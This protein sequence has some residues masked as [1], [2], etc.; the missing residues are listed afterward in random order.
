MRREFYWR[1]RDNPLH[2]DLFEQSSQSLS[3]LASSSTLNMALN[4]EGNVRRHLSDNARPVRKRPVTRIH[5][6]L[7]RNANFLIDSHVISDEAFLCVVKTQKR[8]SNKIYKTEL[9]Q[10]RY[11]IK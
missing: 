7:A 4:D 2:L 11:K 9:T 8:R 10:I 6:P 5:A 1:T 3:S